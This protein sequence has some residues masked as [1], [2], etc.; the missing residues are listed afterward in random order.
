MCHKFKHFIHMQYFLLLTNLVI[1]FVHWVST[2]VLY[3]P[4]E[5]SLFW[6][7][8]PES[9]LRFCPN[10]CRP[11]GPYS[12]RPIQKLPNCQTPTHGGYCNQKQ[13]CGSEFAKWHDIYKPEGART[14]E[15]K[16][17]TIWSYSPGS[18]SRTASWMVSCLAL[19]S[20][21][22]L[23]NSP[24]SFDVYTVSRSHSVVNP[25]PENSPQS[26]GELRNGHVANLQEL[27]YQTGSK[28]G[29]I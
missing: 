11:S 5:C 10:L 24:Q 19:C 13:C 6:D 8:I 3:E 22:S 29:V 27:L 4:R 26:S 23:E 21:Q 16:T 25:A 28:N 12:I 2:G 17:T 1:V 7:Y 15:G 20:W 18:Y 9:K 14:N